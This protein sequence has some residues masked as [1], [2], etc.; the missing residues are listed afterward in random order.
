MDTS[1]TLRDIAL[2]KQD[3]LNHI[4]TGKGERVMQPTFGTIIPDLL[5]EPM[6]DRSISVL[7][8]ELTR[9]IN[10]DPRISLVDLQLEAVPDQNIVRVSVVLRYVELDMVDRLYLNIEFQ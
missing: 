8:N 1:F 9:V 2:V 3:L 5:F 6:D 7:E 4:F 10:S